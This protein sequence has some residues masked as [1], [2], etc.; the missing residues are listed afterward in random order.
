MVCINIL[1][2]T[3]DL[4]LS[5]GIPVVGLNF[6]K[7]IGMVPFVKEIPSLVQLAPKISDMVIN[8][9]GKLSTAVIG[10]LKQQLK[11]ITDLA[12][13]D[14]PDNIETPKSLPTCPNHAS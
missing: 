1:F 14:A 10:K 9:P 7:I 2:N 13:P 8:V 11:L 4:I 12:I 6:Y 3:V 5:T